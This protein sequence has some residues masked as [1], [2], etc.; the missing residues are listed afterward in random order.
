MTSR[1]RIF[2]RSLLL[3]QTDSHYPC[4]CV[5]GCFPSLIAPVENPCLYVMQ[6]TEGQILEGLSPGSAAK[7]A[8]YLLFLSKWLSFGSKRQG[9]CWGPRVTQTWR[10]MMG[11]VIFM[12]N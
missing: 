9:C 11:F 2:I 5:W 7:E 3:K 1:L 8:G 6:Q 4:E 12:N 10:L